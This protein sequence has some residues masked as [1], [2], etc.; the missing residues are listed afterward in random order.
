MSQPAFSEEHQAPL[1]IE[2]VAPSLAAGGMEVVI[3]DLV[4]A[5]VARGHDVGVTC[6]VDEGALAERFRQRGVRVEVVETPG[7]RTIFWPGRLRDWL[8]SRQPDVVHTHSGAWHKG[9]RAARLAGVPATL[10]TVHGMVPHM[11]PWFGAALRR[12]AGEWTDHVVVV[13][14]PLTDFLTDVCG[15][16]RSRVSH[17]ANGIDTD[18]FRPER[19]D[20]PDVW[21]RGEAGVTIGTV[22]RLAPEKNQMLL[23]EGF[24]RIAGDLPRARLVLIGEGPERERLETRARELGLESRVHLPGFSPETDKIYP[25]FDVFTLT[26]NVEGTSI[27][28]LEAM[29]CG[30][31][32]V[33][34]AVGG[35]PEILEYG[36]CGLLVPARDPE[37][38]GNALMA[39]VQDRGIRDDLARRAR[40]RA[41]G[42]YSRE[43]MAA[44]YERLYRTALAGRRS[45]AAGVG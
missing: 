40:E 33:A 3:L 44:A 29:A 7:T 1:R 11:E 38:L 26:S 12:L 27:S 31:P 10:H 35:N 24:A 9:A 6:L 34:T 39:L 41:V 22:A 28:L 20:P 18:R 37:A 19:T 8:R 42:V 36:D 13:S 23:L 14:S 2:M 17:V 5:L 45:V 25:Q 43:A 30:C 15:L 4:E 21:P 32:I 16:N